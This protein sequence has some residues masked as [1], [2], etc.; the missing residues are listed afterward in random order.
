[1]RIVWRHAKATPS[2][3]EQI[4][5][6]V[7][8]AAAS[9]PPPGPLKRTTTEQGDAVPRKRAATG[10][11]EPAVKLESEPVAHR[12]SKACRPDPAATA[13]RTEAA[14]GILALLPRHLDGTTPRKRGRAEMEDIKEPSS[15][16][17]ES[18]GPAPRPL[19]MYGRA[20]AA[21]GVAVQWSDDED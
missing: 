8:A 14:A 4:V 10:N 9:S 16:D 21:P 12:S 7:A 15:S 5:P 1:M 17:G 11:P 2:N 18:C 20:M 19:T 3:Y 13:R 6:D